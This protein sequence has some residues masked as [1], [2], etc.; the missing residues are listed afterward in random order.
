[1]FPQNW[2][3]GSREVFLE[4]WKNAQ[5]LR[6]DERTNASKCITVLVLDWTILIGT[7]LNRFLLSNLEQIDV[8][9][10]FRCLPV[11]RVRARLVIYMSGCGV[12]RMYLFCE[13]TSWWRTPLGKS[14]SKSSSLTWNR[15]IKRS[16]AFA[17]MSRTVTSNVG[18]LLDT[19]SHQL[20]HDPGRPSWTSRPN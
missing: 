16:L 6:N 19:P 17:N 13:G 20:S 7:G 12:V 15:L 5:K 1:M 11:V 3:H 2:K 9:S 14:W 10:E 8:W 4:S 18:L